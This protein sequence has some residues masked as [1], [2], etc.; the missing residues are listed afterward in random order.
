MAMCA[1]GG[2][3]ADI[4]YISPSDNRGAGSW[5]S[6][7]LE[8]YRERN[9]SAVHR[10]IDLSNSCQIDLSNRSKMQIPL[11]KCA[12]YV[13]LIRVTAPN[14]RGIFAFYTIYDLFCC[15]RPNFGKRCFI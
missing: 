5:V 10:Q 7:Q 3:G 6:N 8:R 12:L 1:E 14:R 13:E 9:E 2:S 11:R 15:N 4:E